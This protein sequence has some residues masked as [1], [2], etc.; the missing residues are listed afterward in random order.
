MVSKAEFKLSPRLSPQNLIYIRKY[1]NMSI[2]G[3]CGLTSKFV[4]P[5]PRHVSFERSFH[6]RA[7]AD[8]DANAQFWEHVPIR[9]VIQYLVFPSLSVNGRTQKSFHCSR[10]SLNFEVQFGKQLKIWSNVFPYPE[11]NIEDV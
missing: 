2:W 1:F 4:S 9:I 11:H 6:S 7:H 5:T 10:Y 8:D 3:P